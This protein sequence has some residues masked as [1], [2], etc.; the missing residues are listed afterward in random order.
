M[1]LIHAT[2]VNVKQKKKMFSHFY[3]YFVRLREK[4]GKNNFIAKI[5]SHTGLIQ[6]KA[7]W[8]IVRPQNRVKNSLQF[9]PAKQ[10]G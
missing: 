7:Y 3:L 5:P 4:N 9:T 8:V 2:N 10:L 6:A 1:Y